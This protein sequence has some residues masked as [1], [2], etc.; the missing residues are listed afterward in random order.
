MNRGAVINFVRPCGSK[1]IFH[2]TCSLYRISIPW[3]TIQRSRKIRHN[4]LLNATNYARCN[5]ISRI[6]MPPLH[7]P[8]F[9]ENRIHFSIYRLFFFERYC[10]FIFN[11]FFN[12]LCFSNIRKPAPEYNTKGCKWLTKTQTNVFA[13]LHQF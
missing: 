10:D 1:M 7:F 8:H 4:Y 2:W 9:R 5:V 13:T 11:Q 6:Q 3:C 12:T